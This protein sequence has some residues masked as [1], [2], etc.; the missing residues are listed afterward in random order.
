MNDLNNGVECG[1]SK[2]SDDMKLGREAE[3][4]EVQQVQ[5]PAHREEQAQAP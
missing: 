5:S 2:F 3:F 4:Q 1:P